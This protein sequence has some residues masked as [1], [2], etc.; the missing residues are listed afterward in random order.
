MKNIITYQSLICMIEEVLT[1]IPFLWSQQT[2]MSGY[3]VEVKNWQEEGE[4]QILII[5]VYPATAT[6]RLSGSSHGITELEEGY[7]NT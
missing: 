7:Q 5:C 4:I 2:G 1:G 3:H 6:C